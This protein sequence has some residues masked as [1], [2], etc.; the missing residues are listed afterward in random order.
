M[1]GAPTSD[2]TVDGLLKVFAVDGGVQMPGGDQ[3]R[4]V[5]HVGNIGA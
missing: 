2:D 3:R 4:L 5:A 1:A